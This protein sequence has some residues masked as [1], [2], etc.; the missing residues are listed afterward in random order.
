[1]ALRRFV[2]CFPPLLLQRVLLLYSAPAK[3]R[4]WSHHENFRLMCRNLT[5][6]PVR[7]VFL[8]NERQDEHNTGGNS[9]HPKGVDV[10]QG[11]SLHLNRSVN[12]SQGLPLGLV[13]A[14][15]GVGKLL[16]KTINCILKR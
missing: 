12:S 13:Q 7:I 16:S 4:Y 10:R 6:A 11:G 1:M 15:S 5:A 2:R 9:E 8:Q 14:Q 3:L